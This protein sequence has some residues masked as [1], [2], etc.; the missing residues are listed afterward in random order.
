VVRIVELENELNIENDRELIWGLKY[1]GRRLRNGD[2]SG[3]P[4]DTSSGKD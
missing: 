4:D 1:Y 2:T 3:K